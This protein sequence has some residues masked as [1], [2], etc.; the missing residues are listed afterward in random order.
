[1]SEST[2]TVLEQLIARAIEL[3]E[4]GQP[5]D[6]DALC[7][8]HPVLA[9]SVAAA[10]ARMAQLRA[11]HREVSP[12]DVFVGRVLQQRYRLDERIGAGAMGVVYRATDLAL[13]REVA[14]KMLRPEL[15]VGERMDVRLA[16]EGQVLA[17][18]RHPNVVTVHDRGQAE[19]GRSFVVMELLR[20]ESAASVVRRLRD[21]DAVSR[22]RADLLRELGGEA[23]VADGDVRQVVRWIVATADGLH[24]AHQGGV[25]HRDVKP[26]N[27]FLERGGRVVLLDFG[28]VTSGVHGTRGN[29]GSPFG[30]PAYMA[31]EQLDAGAEP[32][33]RSDVYSLTATL[34]HLLTGRAPFTGTERQVL[35]AIQGSEPRPVDTLRP[36][37]PADL[38]AIV[39][40]GLAKDPSHRYASALALRDDLLAWLEYRPVT[41]RRTSRWTA[42]WRRARR[43]P[44]V[45]TAAAVSL[46]VGLAIGAWQ[47]SV[48]R[49]AAR[50]DRER[51][52]WAQVPPSLV[53]DPPEY[54]ATSAHRRSADT[55]RLIDA[56]VDVDSGSG[57]ALALRAIHRSDGGDLRG[58]AA[59]LETL[60]ALAASPFATAAAASYRRGES[61][62]AMAA[63]PEAPATGGP[64]DRFA[65][66]LH[67][68]RSRGA[69][70]PWVEHLLERDGALDAHPGFAEL[71]LLLRLRRVEA[72][73]DVVLLERI[74]REAHRVQALRRRE[75]A[76][77]LF[78]LM[79]EAVHRVATEDGLALAERAQRLAPEGCPL[80]VVGGRLALQ[81]YHW[82]RAA[83]MFER[84]VQLQPAS[85]HAA[86]GLC[87]ALVG[88]GEYGAAGSLLQTAVFTASPAAV[89]ER[90]TLTGVMLYRRAALGA[91][92]ATASVERGEIGDETWRRHAERAREAFVRVR[93]A[94][95]GADA[96]SIEELLCDCL[97]GGTLP[98]AR[99]LELLSESP[100]DGNLLQL[101]AE[102]LH[103]S[104]QPADV[105]ALRALL[106]QQAE[107]LGQRTR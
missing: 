89:V 19:D 17:R 80:F 25:V 3:Q 30:T 84:A 36:G 50:A 16:R 79:N 48:E 54:R 15:V 12:Q 2:D 52:L 11:A 71:H 94:I 26:S 51:A 5:V 85:L 64:G 32:T 76:I 9:P 49:C 18:I 73:A 6:L 104:V 72:T 106:L 37:L 20:G 103:D 62:D 53:N 35:A 56:L 58:A 105:S 61:P 44:R 33:V 10:L 1:L 63:G 38:A 86:T 4:C 90:D 40:K 68:M 47:W 96:T 66:V 24:A 101:V 59:D 7:A 45:Q 92:A 8:D 69:R 43:S 28:I 98:T 88:M 57:V 107:A 102:H 78:V 31:P 91:E 77:C 55:A 83:T 81:G 39:E 46:L 42:A 67:A 21:G 74:A 70:P 75:S 34:Y 65:A 87:R 27:L 99:A 41:A 97:L 93:A 14:V 22:A 13:L 29:D 95:G 100:L 23:A 60:A 82:A